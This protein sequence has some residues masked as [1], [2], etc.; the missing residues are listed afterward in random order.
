MKG[1]VIGIVILVVLG[2]LSLF[3]F[4]FLSIGSK[5]SRAEEATY[6]EYLLSKQRKEDNENKNRE[7]DQ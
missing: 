1:I 6:R 3:V 5:C 2:L 4:S 7:E